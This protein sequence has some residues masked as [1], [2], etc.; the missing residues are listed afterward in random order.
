[1]GTVD[2]QNSGSVQ[3]GGLTAS[4]SAVS[5]YDENWNHLSANQ[6]A[7]LEAGDEVFFAVSG[8]ASSGTFQK[9][10]F[11]VNGAQPVE[12]TDKRP[13]SQDFYYKY[14]IPAGVTTFKVDADMLHSEL[15][16]F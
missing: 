15:G 14:K 10:R 13:G 3:S 6:L 8:T 16:W 12:V 5:A 11:S 9:A 4:C 1:M 7:Q 2:C